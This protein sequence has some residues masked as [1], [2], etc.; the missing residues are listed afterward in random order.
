LKIF[1]VPWFKSYSGIALRVYTQGYQCLNDRKAEI[2]TVKGQ[3]V[4]LS[5]VQRYS[6]SLRLSTF[7]VMRF[8]MAVEADVPDAVADRLLFVL[9]KLGKIRFSKQIPDALVE[10]PTLE[11]VEHFLSIRALMG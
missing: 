2:S 1:L 10:R 4:A 5:L 9:A 11:S 3:K 6:S 8:R 7:E